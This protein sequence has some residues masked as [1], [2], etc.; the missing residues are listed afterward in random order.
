MFMQ[1]QDSRQKF[2][3]QDDIGVLVSSTIW[4]SF[5][6]RPAHWICVVPYHSEGLSLS[7][8]K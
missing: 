2:Y 8:K 4:L 3:I 5:S 6:L 1:I 7:D